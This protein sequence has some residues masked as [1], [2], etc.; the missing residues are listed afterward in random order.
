MKELPWL[1]YHHLSYFLTIVK[2]GGLTRAA[3]KLHLSQSTLSTQLRQLE[4]SLGTPLFTREG[5]RLVLTPEGEVAVN[6]AEEIFRAGDELR[7]WF[8]GRAGATRHTLTVGAL[9]PLSKNLQFEVIRPVIMAGDYTV[10]VVEGEY[11]DLLDRLKRHQIDLLLSNLSPG[12]VASHG[13]SMHL[14]GEMPVYLVGRP[15]FR[16]QEK[17]FP[18]WLGEVPLFLPSTRTA[19]REGFDAYLIREGI[20]PHIAA[21]VDDMALLRLLAL[22]GAGIALVPEI[23]VKF[24]LEERKLLKIQRVPNL[25]E[26]FFALTARQ[27]FLPVG[28]KSLI[29]NAIHA[30]EGVL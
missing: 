5:R 29:D 24:E 14:L 3:K 7:A 2:E 4:E 9:S 28:V 30:L 13:V 1:N 26:R 11:P 23:G 22:S 27:K 17:S 21:E 16:L 19:A 25:K 10:K 18:R 15:P 20:E 12:E 6:Y 8:S